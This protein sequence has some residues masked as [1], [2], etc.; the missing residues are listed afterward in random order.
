MSINII[1]KELIWASEAKEAAV[2]QEIVQE[3]FQ[4][5]SLSGRQDLGLFSASG[6]PAASSTTTT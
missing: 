2:A 6:P 4:K 1:L 5:D 3:S